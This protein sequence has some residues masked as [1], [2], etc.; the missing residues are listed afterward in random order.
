MQASYRNASFPRPRH[1]RTPLQEAVHYRRKQHLIVGVPRILI[2]RDRN[3][4]ITPVPDSAGNVPRVAGGGGPKVQDDH[5]RVR[6][7]QRLLL[8]M[9]FA[10]GVRLAHGE[11]VAP[12][13]GDGA[14]AGAEVAE[15]G[16]AAVGVDAGGLGVEPDDV[17]PG[18]ET[19]VDEAG[20][21]R[22][23]VAYR[24]GGVGVAGG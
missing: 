15:V 10:A 20:W 18:G 1:R 21:V 8:G 4:L 13:A 12:P 6:V 5:V 23:G 2:A 3:L 19:L 7:A 9:V 24:E 11:G 22:D 17:V 14:A 16:L